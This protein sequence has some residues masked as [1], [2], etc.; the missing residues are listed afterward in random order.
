MG[1]SSEAVAR[2]DLDTPEGIAALAELMKEAPPGAAGSPLRAFVAYVQGCASVA[3]VVAR[4]AAARLVTRPDERPRW[5]MGSASPLSSRQRGPPAKAGL[6]QRSSRSPA[7]TAKIGGLVLERWGQPAVLGELLV[8]MAL[9][10]LVPLV[11]GLHGR[12]WEGI[13]NLGVVQL[14]KKIDNVK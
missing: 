1:F 5:A 2:I 14:R 8:G 10:N 4:A 11:V 12:A 7:D 13:E 3:E 6:T 9:G